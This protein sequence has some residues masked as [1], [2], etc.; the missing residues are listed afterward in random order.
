MKEV[1]RLANRASY[2]P[3]PGGRRCLPPSLPKLHLMEGGVNTLSI[4]VGLHWVIMFEYN[5]IANLLPI[6]VP[7]VISVLLLFGLLVKV[8]KDVFSPGS[9]HKKLLVGDCN[10]VPNR[11]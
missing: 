6:L 2:G 9:N 3:K 10:G 4:T 11:G 8:G 5:E 7:G 1:D